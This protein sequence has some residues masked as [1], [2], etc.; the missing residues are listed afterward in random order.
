MP[1]PPVLKVPWFRL[2]P[3]LLLAGCSL[4]P[5]P[6]PPGPAP[7]AAP[8]P[9]VVSLPPCSPVPPP[10]PEPTPKP[11][12]VPVLLP[13]GWE[14]VEGWPGEDPGAA[15]E[16][17]R[18]SCRVLQN[19]AGWELACAEA[20]YLD[21]EDDEEARAFF[22]T[23]FIPYRVSSP[24]GKE[25]GLITGYYV[26]DLVGSRSC[27]E[28]FAWP[29]YAVPDDLLVIDLRSVYPDL[30]NYRLRGRLVGRKVIPYWSRAEIDGDEAPLVGKEL[31][32]VDD[33]VALFFLHIQGSGRVSLEDGSRVMVHYA[34]QNGYPF[35][36]I[37]KLLL[38]RGE[39]TRDQMSM[40]AIQ[41]WALANPDRVR[42]LLSENPSYIFF[43]ELPSSDEPPPGALG[44]P[45]TP[46]R[47]LAVDPRTIPLGAPL[48]LSTTWPSSREPLQRLMLAQDTGGAIKGEVRADF[49]WGLG[50][51]AGALAGRMKQQGRYWLLYPVHALPPGVASPVGEAAAAPPAKAAEAAR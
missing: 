36:S 15:L 51:E 14:A 2:L 45:L 5:S 43:T 6:T 30:A 47:S 32:W 50:D 9:A 11:E 3:V 44:V 23:L 31:L 26:P 27:S 22:E 42:Q 48:F 33:P 7:P 24:A 1:S 35:R 21:P 12:P 17:F 39:M 19:R 37:G 29:L 25:T 4:L 38:E 20:A 13:V 28:R 49:F 10:P 46:G 8:P 16:A 18:E 34:D 40:Q 41:A